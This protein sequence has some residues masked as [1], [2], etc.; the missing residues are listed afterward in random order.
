MCKNQFKQKLIVL[1]FLYHT[2]VY[3]NTITINVFRSLLCAQG[4]IGAAHLIPT[5]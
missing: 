4:A 2:K 1:L 5:P 3:R